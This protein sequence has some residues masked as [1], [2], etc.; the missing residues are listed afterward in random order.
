MFPPPA[1]VFVTPALA[2]AGLLL[3]SVPIIIHL[4]NRR[5]FKTVE[6]AAMRFVLEA[7]RRNR[8]RLQFESW[9]LLAMRC[10]LVSL[11]GLALA[12]PLGCAGS[13][14]A[15]AAGGD[16]TLHVFV[17]DNSASTGAKRGEATT[18]DLMKQ[19][20]AAV[21]QTAGG[22]ARAAV[23]SAAAPAGEVVP[24]PAYDLTAVEAASMDVEQTFAATDLAGA[25]DRVLDLVAA[26]DAG[27]RIVVHVLTDAAGSAMS[28][29]RLATL[30]PR[31]ETATAEIRLYLPEGDAPQNTAVVA[32][33]PDDTIIRRGFDTSLLGTVTGR[34]ESAAWS[35]DGRTIDTPRL[36]T[37]SEVVASPTVLDA[38][39][40]G[41]PHLVQLSLASADD[42][43][44]FDDSR[45][46][47]VQE[48]TDLPV[49]VV[50][51][52]SAATA[53]ALGGRSLLATAL[54]PGE[55]G[56]I[57]VDR[58]SDLELSTRPLGDY[59]AV[60]LANVAGFDDA[61]AARLNDFVRSG[62]TLMIWLG[63]GI[64]LDTYNATLG[65][66]GIL[67]GRIERIVNA[68]AASQ[69]GQRALLGFDFDPGDPHRFLG[70][71]RGVD[72]SGLSAPT[73]RRYWGVTPADSAEVVLAFAETQDPAVLTARVGS[74]AVTLVTTSA[75]DPEWT[76]L[77]L[78]DNY[79]A[80]VHELFRGTVG[81]TGGGASW[82]NLLVGD[83]LSIPASAGL[84]SGSTPRLIGLG[85]T[86]LLTREAQSGGLS[87]WTSPP[88]T[89][90]GAYEVV[91]GSFRSPIAVNVL[92]AESDLEPASAE[93]VRESLGDIDLE[94][95]GLSAETAGVLVESQDRPD[96]G[97]PVLL[98]AGFVAAGESA[99]AAF[100]SR[101]R[102]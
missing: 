62:G 4:L 42:A 50:E 28:E 80:F 60:V 75:D 98:L 24:E 55:A 15:A 102:A 34:A 32:V 93:A 14:L 35:V 99:Y 101:R 23:I 11:I 10:L 44:A 92:A 2:A 76:L 63:E 31:L 21:L 84:P 41:R 64:S 5:R 20:V 25:L 85:E 79:A 43:L 56:Y 16:R 88:L 86:I 13:A 67:P 37:D 39:R 66:L 33:S 51:G 40:D 69:D 22:E 97:W 78:I 83:H 95:V 68:D 53:A 87:R 72:R 49:L 12:R 26:S 52:R 94:V 61:T 47:V 58:I 96:W 89:V 70:A 18:L 71:F 19:T 17:L 36:G 54:A 81:E 29:A 91:A 8:R 77:P 1:A 100:L 6:W 48:V 7:M 9:L 90:P 57:K 38:V 59:E 30:G 74:G 82:Q 45:L 3:A 46:R 27:E 65:G 73:I